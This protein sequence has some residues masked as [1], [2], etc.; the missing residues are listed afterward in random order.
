M[1]SKRLT[2][3]QAIKQYCK[4]SCCAGSI[5]DWRECS[6]YDCYLWKFRTGKETLAKPKSF[7][8]QRKTSSNLPKISIPEET[9][10]QEEVKQ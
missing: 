9:S 8:K 2:R 7:K 10:K 3:G 5:V 1:S 6:A 4:M